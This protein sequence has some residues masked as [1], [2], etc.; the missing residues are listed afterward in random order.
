MKKIFY[1]MLAATI[2]T[3]MVACDDDNDKVEVS[4]ISLDKETL[5]LVVDETQQLTA[6]VTPEDADDKTVVWTSDNTD[7][8]TVN[9]EGVVTAVAAGEAVVTAAA[10]EKTATCTVTVTESVKP[11]TAVKTI[12][13]PGDM[14]GFY[15]Q[16]DLTRG[17]DGKVTAIKKEQQTPQG[18]QGE[19]TEVNITY[20]TDKVT[21]A[22][23][24]WGENYEI[25]FSLNAEGYVTGAKKFYEGEPDGETVFAYGE[26]NG[27]LEK[28]SAMM[29]DE[30]DIFTAT[31]GDDKN[32]TTVGLDLEES[33]ELIDYGCVASDVKN[34]A[35]VDL[36][37]FMFCYGL[38]NEVDYAILCGLIP[39]T[40]NLLESVADG[41][42]EFV[43]VENANGVASVK[44]QAEGQTIQECSLDY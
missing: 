14:E 26:S 39:S 36:N 33:G 20:A 17:E 5:D 11:A 35:G 40:P 34:D 27:M 19:A 18:P 43:T 32:Y 24:E 7:V 38:L 28:I 37:M 21:F 42:I 13:I 10:G 1:L 31:Y 8:V 41:Y 22:Y 4:G 3:A 25:E 30:A 44:M 12:K 23:Q 9:E 6:T 29:D 2:G 16:I 15:T